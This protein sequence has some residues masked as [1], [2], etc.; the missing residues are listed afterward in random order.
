VRLPA[1]LDHHCGLSV[2]GGLAFDQIQNWLSAAYNHVNYYD[3][4]WCLPGQWLC[5]GASI[6]GA[7]WD[8]FYPGG[9]IWQY[10]VQ[11]SGFNILFTW[12]GIPIGFQENDY[13]G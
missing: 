5:S 11:N 2:C 3:Y 6:P 9:G 1:G 4:L 7:R 12:V 10:P 8:P 13:S